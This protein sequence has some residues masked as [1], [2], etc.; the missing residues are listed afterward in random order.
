MSLKSIV[1]CVSSLRKEIT[2][3]EAMNESISKAV[4]VFIR[5]LQDC[6]VKNPLGE[7]RA[8]WYLENL[9]KKSL[10]RLRYGISNDGTISRDIVSGSDLEWALL[11]LVRT[12]DQYCKSKNVGWEYF[13]IPNGSTFFRGLAV[14]F[15]DGVGIFGDDPFYYAKTNC[16]LVFK[17]WESGK[18]KPLSLL[19]PDEG[20]DDV[21]NPEEMS[22]YIKRDI[23]DQISK[24]TR[25]NLALSKYGGV[26]EWET[27]KLARY[28]FHINQ[29]K[30]I[31]EVHY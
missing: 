13:I 12:I 19:K 9:V 3:F 29:V 28:A 30:Y 1:G 5:A 26:L 2:D 6:S 31:L 15:S 16:R 8:F 20:F 25:V 7:Y 24:E 21:E 18:E 23:I 4:N 14:L 11:N 22:G 17:E 10:V 27:Y